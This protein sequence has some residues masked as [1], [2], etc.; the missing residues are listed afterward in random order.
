MDLAH[1][2]TPKSDQLNAD[3]LLAG[4]I[5]ITIK[6]VKDVGGDQPIVI[7]YEGDNGRPYKPG[8]SMRRVMIAMWGANGNDW[9]GQSIEIYNDPEVRFGGQEVGGIR[10]SRATGI[11]KTMNIMLTVTRAKRAPYTVKPLVIE[12]AEPAITEYPE[13]KFQADLQKMKAAIES[14]KSSRDSIIAHLE[15]TAPI[16]TAQRETLEA[17]S[18]VET[19]TF[20]EEY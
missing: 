15:K 6:A 4:P 17:I 11:A 16:T 3:D 13:D 7:N 14:G 5:T 9:I 10:I 19:T 8:K 2:V 1:T 12:Q 20:E 18:P